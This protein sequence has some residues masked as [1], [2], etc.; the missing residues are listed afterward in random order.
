MIEARGDKSIQL[1][2]KNILGEIFCDYCFSN[3]K[4][5]TATVNI[6]KSEKD[7]EAELTIN[8]LVFIC[9]ESLSDYTSEKIATTVAAGKAVL[10]YAECKGKSVPPY[11]VLTGVRPFKIASRLLSDYDDNTTK[12]ILN[13]RFLISVDKADLLIEVAKKDLIARNY[14][15]DNDCSLYLSIPFCPTRCNYCS[16]ISSSAPSLLNII[17]AYVDMLLKE[18]SMYA[19][20]I[21][22]TGLN[23]KS[24][25]IGGGTP[26]VLNELQLNRL[27]SSV[28]SLLPMNNCV[29]F[30]VEAGRPD[31]ITEKKLEVLKHNAVER[32]CINCQTT[33]D[34]VLKA[35][36]RSHTKNDFFNAFE[37]A[38]LY[39]FKTINTDI[40]A[41]L[42]SDTLDSF[43]TTVNDVIALAPENVT[44]HSLAL[45]KSSEIKKQPET[46]IDLSII[47]KCIDY[48]KSA[49]I[50]AGYLPYYLYRQKYSAG[51][52]ENIGYSKPYHESYYNV[53]MMNEIEHIFGLGAGATSR[54]VDYTPGAKIAHFENYKYPIEYVK[55]FEKVENNIIQMENYIKTLMNT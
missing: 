39:G 33:S 26:T 47:D 54:I 27:V 49:C 32:I 24:V 19:D 14:H 31:T 25:Y 36:G 1:Y 7:I 53:A 21:R 8:D 30:T 11:G 29:E 34:T 52:H 17:D 48:S 41:G 13:S 6:T 55:N 20:F 38:K 12:E 22:R 5:I 3:T 45:K 4:N 43:I 15:S 18:V 42:D 51:N 23:I 44:V 10:Q 50:S 37:K 28:T 16:F 40:I 46:A 9:K 2:V 35:I